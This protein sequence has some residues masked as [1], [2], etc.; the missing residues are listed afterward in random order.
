[1]TVANAAARGISSGAVWETARRLNLYALTN[2]ALDAL[3]TQHHEASLLV[4]QV[5]AEAARHVRDLRR[6]SEAAG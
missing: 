5:T 2:I 3:I 6:A 4:N 1:M